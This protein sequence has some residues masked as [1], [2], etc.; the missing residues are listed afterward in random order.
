MAQMS[1]IFRV[2]LLKV[3]LGMKI[4]AKGIRALK[5]IGGSLSPAASQLVLLEMVQLI[6]FLTRAYVPIG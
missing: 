2:G 4:I 1:R 3:K 5:R 6:Q